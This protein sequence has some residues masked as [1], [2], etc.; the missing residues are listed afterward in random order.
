V[1]VYDPETAIRHPVSGLATSHSAMM[2]GV[3]HRQTADPECLSHHMV[4]QNSLGKQF[5]INVIGRVGINGASRV[6]GK[7]Q[8]AQSLHWIEV[9][10]VKPTPGPSTPPRRRRYHR[11]AKARDAQREAPS[12]STDL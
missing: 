10:D 5:G 12:S 11:R 7:K 8:T 9:E 2:I 3:G 4:M 1:Y 6:V